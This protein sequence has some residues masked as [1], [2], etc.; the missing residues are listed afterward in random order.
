[1]ATDEA[2]A[3][4]ELLTALDADDWSVVLQAVSVADNSIRGAIV[5]DPRG[6]TSS[7]QV[8]HFGAVA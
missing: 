6:C 8:G 4:E 3:H 1:M 2:V 7:D 5:G